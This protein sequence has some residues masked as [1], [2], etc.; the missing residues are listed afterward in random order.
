MLTLYLLWFPSLSWFPWWIV[1]ILYIPLL[2]SVI[3]W[4]YSHSFCL[5][6]CIIYP[7]KVQECGKLD[8][9]GPRFFE[10]YVSCFYVPVKQVLSTYLRKTSNQLKY[11]L[12]FSFLRLWVCCLNYLH[13]SP[14]TRVVADV[15]SIFL[16]IQ[17][18]QDQFLN[19]AT[20]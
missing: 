12:T 10:I 3:V 16:K 7:G 19:L 1:S 5:L 17:K 20:M 8:W 18:I 4:E 2:H 15:L 13:P 11:A 6:V 14:S 9:T